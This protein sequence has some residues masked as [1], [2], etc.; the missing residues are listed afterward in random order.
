MK[1]NTKSS[2]EQDEI[3]FD[4]GRWFPITT[5][6]VQWPQKVGYGGGHLTAIFFILI[7]RIYIPKCPFHLLSVYELQVEMYLY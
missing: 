3:V 5:S 2:K 6:V 4:N 1:P 7:V